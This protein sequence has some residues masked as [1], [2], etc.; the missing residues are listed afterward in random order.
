MGD[1]EKLVT[2]KKAH[3][4]TCEIYRVT[5]HLPARHRFILGDQMRRA[6]LSI[7]TNIVE[8]CGRNHDGHF[9]NSLTTSLGEANELH[10][11]LLVARDVRAM[12]ADLAMRLRT[13]TDEVRRLLSALLAAVK[14]RGRPSRVNTVAAQTKAA[15]TEFAP[16]SK[17]TD[18]S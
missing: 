12:S 10:Y 2:W 7:A 4:L 8:G 6:A 5:E 16:P 18:S 14:Q 9:R 13:A 17:P 3:R 1:Y 15:R 11:L